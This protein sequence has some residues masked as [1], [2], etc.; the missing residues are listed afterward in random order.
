[1]PLFRGTSA[2][3]LSVVPKEWGTAASSMEDA[4]EGLEASRD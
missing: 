1:M 2:T 3:N 4:V